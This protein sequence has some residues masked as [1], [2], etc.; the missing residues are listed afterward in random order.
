MQQEAIWRWLACN[1]SDAVFKPCHEHLQDCA[2]TGLPPVYALQQ[3]LRWQITCMN[4]IQSSSRFANSGLLT[5]TKH[6]TRRQ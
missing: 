5:L 3:S 1:C 2:V 6:E 4:V